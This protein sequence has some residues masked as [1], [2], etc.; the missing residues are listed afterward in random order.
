MV[1]LRNLTSDIIQNLPK[2]I[3]SFFIQFSKDI[4]PDFDF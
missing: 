2:T 4:M 1:N 3:I